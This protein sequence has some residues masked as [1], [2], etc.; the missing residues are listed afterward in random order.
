M[1]QEIL[2]LNEESFEQIKVILS[3]YSI[4]VKE[5]YDKLKKSI[6]SL[7]SEWNDEDYQ[8]LFEAIKNIG[9]KLDNIDDDTKQ[10]I[11]KAEYKIEMINARKSI[12]L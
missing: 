7:S 5:H 2:D 6:I 1:P 3:Q 11:S 9:P 8:R 4:S 12:K 10:M